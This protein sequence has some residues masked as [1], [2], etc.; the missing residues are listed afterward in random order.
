MNVSESEFAPFPSKIPSNS[1]GFHSRGGTGPN[2][3][4]DQASTWIWTREGGGR[5]VKRTRSLAGA[6]R[7]LISNMLFHFVD[8]NIFPPP[9]IFSQ[10]QCQS[11]VLGFQT[12]PISGA[13]SCPYFASCL[14]Q[15]KGLPSIQSKQM[16]DSFIKQLRHSK[17]CQAQ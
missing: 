9:F 4:R 12:V 10:A 2:I 17:K 1:L 5:N 7:Q 8:T 15:N 16:R 3:G 6:C 14:S 13:L 11:P